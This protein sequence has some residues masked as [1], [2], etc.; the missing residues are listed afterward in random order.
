MR[1]ASVP[2]KKSALFGSRFAF[3]LCPMWHAAALPGVFFSRLKEWSCIGLPCF[4]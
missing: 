1:L 4:D 2:S 3:S